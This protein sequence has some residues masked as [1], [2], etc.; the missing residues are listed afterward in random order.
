MLFILFCFF[1]AAD[2]LFCVFDADLLSTATADLFQR[3]RRLPQGVT[4]KH[5]HMITI[6]IIVSLAFIINIITIIIIIIIT[7]VIVIN[8]FAKESGKDHIKNT[9]HKEG[10]HQVLVFKL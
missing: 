9:R 4:I 2:I 1:D 8:D 6:V 7:I 10:V 5:P 3:H